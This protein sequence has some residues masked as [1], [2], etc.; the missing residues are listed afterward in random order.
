MS[1]IHVHKIKFST[2][3]SILTELKKDTNYF[4]I[5]LQHLLAP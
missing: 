4:K 1:K 3:Y 2:N 5:K